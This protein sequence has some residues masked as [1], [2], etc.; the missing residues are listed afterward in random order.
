MSSTTFNQ[1]VDSI[2]NTNNNDVSIQQIVE[3]QH[4]LKSFGQNC[5]NDKPIMD[6]FN[7]SK[8]LQRLITVLTFDDNNKYD[9]QFEILCVLSNF[10]F[11]SSE[12]VQLLIEYNCHNIALSLF[13]NSKSLRVK[14]QAMYVLLFF[15]LFFFS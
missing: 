3:L 9:L 1:L 15:F 2:I 13:E 5:V 6:K 12:C 8:I 14:S 11:A 4:E 10:A 7:G